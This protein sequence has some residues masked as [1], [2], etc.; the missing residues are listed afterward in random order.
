MAYLLSVFNLSNEFNSL[1]W[2]E[3]VNEKYNAEECTLLA[4]IE[5]LDKDD[6]SND[7]TLKLSIKRLNMYKQVT[8]YLLKHCY[9]ESLCYLEI[10]YFLIVNITSPQ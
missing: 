1:H 4:A 3:S 10:F 5:K 8:S 7:N 6:T 2:F 9:R